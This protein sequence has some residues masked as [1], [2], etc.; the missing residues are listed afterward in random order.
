MVDWE[1]QVVTGII[2]GLGHGNEFRN[3]AHID[4]M[5][6]GGGGQVYTGL[7]NGLGMGMVSGMMV[8]KRKWLGLKVKLER[9]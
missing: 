1:G 8:I 2:N 5:V 6:G 9:V 4:E 3:N 7:I